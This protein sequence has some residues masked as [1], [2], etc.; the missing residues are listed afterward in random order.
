[1]STQP[2]TDLSAIFRGT[3]RRARRHSRA[4]ARTSTV[5]PM[6]R[7][8]WHYYARMHARCT[9][10]G[11]LRLRRTA[12]DLV[13][14]YSA[15]GPAHS[16]SRSQQPASHTHRRPVPRPGHGCPGWA[17]AGRG[18]PDRR[19]A[20]P[21]RLAVR[22][23]RLQGLLLLF[24][25]CCAAACVCV[26]ASASRVCAA[27]IYSRAVLVGLRICSCCWLVGAVRKTSQQRPC[28][29]LARVAGRTIFSSRNS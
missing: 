19:T 6:G 16:R 12:L 28:D 7:H 20:A 27:S 1:M 4:T 18:A 11:L 13:P 15:S 14:S 3:N 8:M 10:R 23:R 9:R 24:C 22:L 26:R 5:S 29:R 21:R 2:A 17:P 25:L